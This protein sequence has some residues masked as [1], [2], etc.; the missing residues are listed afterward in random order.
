MENLKTLPFQ[1]NNKIVEMVVAE[2]E[3]CKKFRAQELEAHNALWSAVHEQ[4]PE[5]DVKGNYALNCEFARQG[6]VMISTAK[7]ECDNPK[8]ALARLLGKMVKEIN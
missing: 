2:H 1:V 3:L 7:A 6:V 8:H 4:Y 5:L